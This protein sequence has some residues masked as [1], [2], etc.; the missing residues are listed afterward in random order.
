MERLRPIE[1]EKS[2][3]P[4]KFKGYERAAVDD[5]K[6]RCAKELETVLAELKATREDAERLRAEVEG[7]RAQENTLKEALVLAQRTA[8]ETKAAAHKESDVIV[9]RARNEAAE[10]RRDLESKL[11]D[12]RW[13]LEKARL[14]KQQF[15]GNFRAMLEDH[16]RNLTESNPPL[17]VV[18]GNADSTAASG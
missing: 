15:L 2:L 18:D 5:F 11:T 1:I 16:L 12:V 9:E 3:F 6:A 17:A 7:F 13:D 8:D 14:E 4:V 10:L